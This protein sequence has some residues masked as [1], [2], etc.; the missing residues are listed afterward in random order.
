M[1]IIVSQAQGGIF[2]VTR[3]KTLIKPLPFEANIRIT[4]DEI[5][6]EVNRLFDAYFWPVFGW[7]KKSDKFEDIELILGLSAVEKRF[8]RKKS[9]INDVDMELVR[10]NIGM[11]HKVQEHV[12]ARWLVP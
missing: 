8:W 6:E 10:H 12:K 4:G 5:G 3:G 2:E 1:V 9:Y 11:R 7:E